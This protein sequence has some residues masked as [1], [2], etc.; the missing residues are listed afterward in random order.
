MPS[1]QNV[2]SEELGHI[3]P[4]SIA[5]SDDAAVRVLAAIYRGGYTFI[6]TDGPLVS[7]PAAPDAAQA[8]VPSTNLNF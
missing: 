5:S 6:R 4:G 2:I 3:F 8:P 1:L 7:K